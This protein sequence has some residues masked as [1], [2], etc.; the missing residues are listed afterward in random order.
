MSGSFIELFSLPRENIQF[1]LRCTAPRNKITPD[2][3]ALEMTEVLQLL[4]ILTTY[5]HRL[6]NSQFKDRNHHELD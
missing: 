2:S 6:N 3:I 5:G 1:L 4:L